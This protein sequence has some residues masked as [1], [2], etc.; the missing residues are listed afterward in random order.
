MQRGSGDRDIVIDDQS[1]VSLREC[2]VLMKGLR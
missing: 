2:E 1:W